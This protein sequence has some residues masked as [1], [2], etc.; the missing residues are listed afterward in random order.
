[1]TVNNV[2]KVQVEDVR[3]I[4]IWLSVVAFLIVLMVVIGGLTRL[5]HSGLSMVE[6]RPVTGWLPPLT[7][8]EWNSQ[9]SNYRNFAEYKQY[10]KGM[11]LSDFKD[12][13]WLEYIHRLLGRIIGLAFVVPFLCFAVLKMIP[14]PLYP[15][16]LFMLCLGTVQGGIGWWMVKSGL[17][18]EPDISQYR[19]AI[20]LSIALA[21][22]VYIIWVMLNLMHPVVSTGNSFNGSTLLLHAKSLLG[23]LFVTIFSGALVAGLD[24]GFYFNEFPLMGG[25]FFPSDYFELSPWYLNMF[26]NISAVQFDHRWLAVITVLFIVWLFQRARKQGIKGR[27]KVAVNTMAVIAIV[28]VGLGISTLLYSVPIFLASAHQV[29]ALLLLSS[30]VWALH[31]LRTHSV[32]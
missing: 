9:F 23:F 5:T 6:W 14:Q 20:H 7:L 30:A 25:R 18:S 28:Q 29:G 24:A 22:L 31:E 1:M 19:L 16:L 2:S 32:R 27:A 15:K 17:A 12:I 26:E 8:E 3:K 13:F 21:I 4:V 11:S 10:N